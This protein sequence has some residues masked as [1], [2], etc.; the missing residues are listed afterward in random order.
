MPLGVS[1]PKH[2]LR[3]LLSASVGLRWGLRF[4]SFNK[5]HG[6][7]NAARLKGMWTVCHSFLK[8]IFKS[9]KHPCC[10][11]PS[12]WNIFLINSYNCRWNWAGPCGSLGAQSLSVSPVS[13]EFQRWVQ[14]LANQGREGMQRQQ[15]NSQ[16]TI[17][18]P[19]D[20]IP[21]SA[22][23]DAQNSLFELFFRIKISNKWKMLTTDEAVTSREGKESHLR[24]DERMQAL[25]TLILISKPDLEPLLWNSSTIPL[26]WDALTFEG[27]A[28]RVALCLAKQ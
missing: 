28:H 9:W 15:R 24:P 12:W 18:Q 13:Y 2:Y 27:E 6:I 20:R 1:E 3:T 14:T 21:G 11:V 22:S 5:L 23:R 4:C 17:G 8:P 19:C 7:A 25:H 16:E 26:G 10:F